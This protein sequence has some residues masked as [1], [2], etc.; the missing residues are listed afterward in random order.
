MQ[1]NEI[2]PVPEINP[3]ESQKSSL[4]LNLMRVMVIAGVLSVVAGIIN[5]FAAQTQS[6]AP[7]TSLADGLFNIGM[8][9]MLVICS[10]FLTKG[11][12]LVIWLFGATI[13][14]SVVYSYAM[15]RGANYIIALAGGYVL[16]QLYNLKKNK[17]LV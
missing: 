3:P 10:R 11:K 7:K 14:G 5:L 15:G 1:N 9:V 17:E 2:P 16:V 12:S 13:L 8:G 6:L 4:F